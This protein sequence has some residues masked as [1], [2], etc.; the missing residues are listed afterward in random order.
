MR[1]RF[2]VIAL[3]LLASVSLGAQNRLVPPKGASLPTSC[4]IGDLFTKT[5]ATAGLYVCTAANTWSIVSSGTVAGAYVAGVGASY[6]IAR[7]AITLDGTNPSSAA[8]GLTT[9]V[10]CTV[11]GPAAAAIPTDD[12][13]GAVAFINTTSIDLYAWK[14]DG[15]D[16]TPV[17]ST[18]STAV[19]YWICV[20]T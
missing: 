8:T 5:A 20:G 18:N 6:K 7:G 16:P 13:M 11:S 3:A 15:T 17:A 14:T 10:A 9:I 2:S 12:P 19:F 4:N 1:I